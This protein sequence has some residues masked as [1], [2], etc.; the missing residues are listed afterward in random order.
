MKLRPPP[1]PLLSGTSYYT[2]DAHR[3]AIERTCDRVAEAIR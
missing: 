3:G 1:P 2:I